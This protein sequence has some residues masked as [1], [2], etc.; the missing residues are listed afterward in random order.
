MRDIRHCDVHGYFAAESCP[1]CGGDG[2]HVLSHDRRRQVSKFIS[3]ALRHFPDDVGL[4]LG[5]AGWTDAYEVVDRVQDKYA[6]ADAR[7]VAAIVAT[8]SKGRFEVDGNRIRAAY[9]HSVDVTF[10]CE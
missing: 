2:E 6:F 10:G 1:G 8:D 4:T 9:G 5:D 7:T 3:G